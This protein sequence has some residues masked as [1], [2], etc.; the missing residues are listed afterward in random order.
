MIFL[1]I[2]KNNMKQKM[3]QLLREDYRNLQKEDYD[4]LKMMKNLNEDLSKIA[5]EKYNNYINADT[6]Y[7]RNIYRTQWVNYVISNQL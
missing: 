2:Q 4:I 6:M 5:S 1:Q 7:E 3:N